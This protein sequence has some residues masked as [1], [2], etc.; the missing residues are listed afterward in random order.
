MGTIF[1]TGL[2]LPE[3]PARLDDGSWLFAELALE[4]GCV[5]HVDEAGST[6][7]LVAKTGRPNGI[8]VDR[9]GSI[10]VAESLDPSIVR[11]ELEGAAEIWVSSC[12]GEALLWPNDLCFG[13]DGA[14][15]AT[16]SGVRVGEFLEGDGPRPDYDSLTL[17]GRVCRFDLATGE[18]R[19]LDRG[20]RFPNGIAFGPDGSLYVNETMT[21]NV[22]RYEPADGGVREL[23]AN[24][25]DPDFDGGGLRGP[26]GMKFDA[27]GR[28]Y[29]TV[30]GQGDVTVLDRAGQTVGRI[31]TIG[32]APTNLA[33]GPPGSRRIF[34][35]E[36][37]Y[38]QVE[39]HDALAD[40]HALHR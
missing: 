26:D 33:F 31:P 14:L 18:G 32:R 7:R 3:G 40:G 38:G 15:Y 13:P 12:D 34:V 20:L 30:F 17:D 4:R 6:K 21:G 8:A 37:E 2:A 1:C 36:D 23:F 19:L 35:A 10:W 11:L 5:T 24:V 22:Y 27:D 28:L 9:A 29:V 16:D 25:L 39:V